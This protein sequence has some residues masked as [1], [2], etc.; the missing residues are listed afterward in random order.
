MLGNNSSYSYC[1]D[2]KIKH[3][4][5][6]TACLLRHIIRN[7]KSLKYFSDA[8][9]KQMKLTW[10]GDVRWIYLKRK[11]EFSRSR[12]GLEKRDGTCDR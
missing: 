10:S 5:I 3:V 6:L 9:L 1:T 11:R 8:N 7:F 2:C 4:N 12:E